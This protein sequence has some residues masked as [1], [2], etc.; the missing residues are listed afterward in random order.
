MLVILD[1]L[2]CSLICLLEL[3]IIFTTGLL[4]QLIVY[5]LTQF[6]IFNFIK[7]NVEK[8]IYPSNQHRYISK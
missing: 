5:R 7:R 6:S 1:A 8:E 4:V 3:F 2:A